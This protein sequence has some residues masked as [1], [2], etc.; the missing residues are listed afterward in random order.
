MQG[1][2][3]TDAFDRDFGVYVFT[4]NYEDVYH[5][6]F[7]TGYKGTAEKTDKSLLTNT[8]KY[9]NSSYKCNTLNYD[10]YLSDSGSSSKSSSFMSLSKSDWKRRS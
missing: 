7:Y 5:G 3:R 1:A 6:V 10:D 2:S 8:C 9:F 4:K